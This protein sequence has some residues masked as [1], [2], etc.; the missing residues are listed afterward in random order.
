MSIQYT[1]AKSYEKNAEVLGRLKLKVYGL[2]CAADQVEG[3]SNHEIAEKL[4]VP[5]ATIS[6]LTRPL[7][8]EG[9]V[10]QLKKRP[11]K[12]TGHTVIAWRKKD[13]LPRLEDMR[14]E[15]HGEETQQKLL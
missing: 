13:D 2:I 11:C 1:S 4:S 5:T 7:V 14:R 9:L 6:G 12:I 10:W 15:I 8:K 3:I